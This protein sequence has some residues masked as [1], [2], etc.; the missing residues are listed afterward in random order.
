MEPLVL[1][2]TNRTLDGPLDPSIAAFSFV[3]SLLLTAGLG[4]WASRLA[5]DRERRR[6][7]ELAQAMPV[8]GVH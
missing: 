5:R 8:G 2:L 4:W 3:T 7:E 6:R 1:A